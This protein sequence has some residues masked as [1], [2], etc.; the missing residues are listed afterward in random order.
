MI[1]RLAVSFLLVLLAAPAVF[2]AGF[3]ID[4]KQ[5]IIAVV[6][7]KGGF[8]SGLG[9]NHFIAARQF[10]SRL[11]FD[12]DSPADTRFELRLRVEDLIAD[13]PV[14][15]KSW[16]TRL[17]ELGILDEP[18]AELSE[19]D[20]EKIRRAMLGKK[21]LDSSA[22]PTIAVAVTGI[23]LNAPD[24]ESA[25]P[26][27]V[28]LTLEVLGRRVERSVRARYALSDET[29][30]VEAAGTFRFTDFGIKPYS[31]ALGAVKNLDEFHVYATLTARADP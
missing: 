19:K 22:F 21:Q 11:V 23:E 27:E 30:I 25:L 17:K 7:H 20:R 31:A 28:T 10:D 16:S 3:R 15:R 8:A 24:Q 2:G 13:D 14:L 9:H 12:P 18:F 4:E 5:S 26:H 1:R 6:I 29:L